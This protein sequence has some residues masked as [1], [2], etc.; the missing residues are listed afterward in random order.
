MSVHISALQL[1]PWISAVSLQMFIWELRKFEPGLFALI[2][3][4]VF[5]KVPIIISPSKLYLFFEKKSSILDKVDVDGM[6]CFTIGSNEYYNRSFPK[7]VKKR[8]AQNVRFTNIPRY[9]FAD[10]FIQKIEKDN[11]ITGFHLLCKS[12]IIPGKELLFIDLPFHMVQKKGQFFLNDIN[13]ELIRNGTSVRKLTKYVASNINCEDIF[14]VKTFP[15][16]TD[17]TYKCASCLENENPNIKMKYKTK[18]YYPWLVCANTD[19]KVCSNSYEYGTPI[20]FSVTQDLTRKD[21]KVR[22]IA[23]NGVI[24]LCQQMEDT[25]SD[26]KQKSPHYKSTSKDFTVFYVINVKSEGSGHQKIIFNLDTTGWNEKGRLLS[27]DVE[28]LIKW[29]FTDTF[30]F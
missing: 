29:R 12:G 19:G 18:K 17:L 13:T 7:E 21:S 27:K 6:Q 10:N 28:K 14:K 5:Y 16:H 26:L 8:L 20:Q 9:F 22:F 24:G 1:S 3:D 23:S 30:L 2:M 4:M 11:H 25:I 15:E